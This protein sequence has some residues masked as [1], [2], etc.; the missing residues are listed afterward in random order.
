VADDQDQDLARVTAR[1]RGALDSQHG[2]LRVVDAFALAGFERP[3][4][5]RAKIVS[6]ALR[7]LGWTR[8]RYR[9]DGELSYAYA[10]GTPLEREV[11]LDVERSDDDPQKFVVKRREP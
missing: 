7:Q 5:V 11:I 9:F 1:L 6:L 4:Y 8:G 10:R 3:S 2:K